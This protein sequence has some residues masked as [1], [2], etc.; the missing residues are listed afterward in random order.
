[1][2]LLHDRAESARQEINW[3]EF[4]RQTGA[5]QAEAAQRPRLV[6]RWIP[7]PASP[8]RMISVWVAQT[9]A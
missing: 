2:S 7:D 9:E 4:L 3:D 5:V 6:C 1:M 8:D